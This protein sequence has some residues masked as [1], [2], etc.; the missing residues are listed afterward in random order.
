MRVFFAAGAKRVSLKSEGLTLLYYKKLDLC[1][2]RKYYVPPKTEHNI[3]MGS[4]F[5]HLA[6]IWKSATLEFKEY[7]K[8]YAALY[9]AQYKADKY[10]LNGYAC[11]TKL[12]F[13]WRKQNPELDLTKLT[14]EDTLFGV[15]NKDL[16]DEQDGEAI[17][18]GRE[19]EGTVNGELLMVKIK[20]IFENQVQECCLGRVEPG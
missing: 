15:I 9:N 7:F 20:N 2:V 12:M 10:P 3:R 16:Q 6:A 1:Y 5:T 17:I 14:W 19:W 8:N 18:N 11:F 13:D 4:I